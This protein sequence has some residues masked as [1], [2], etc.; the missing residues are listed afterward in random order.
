MWKSLLSI[1]H[2]P[3]PAYVF[4]VSEAGISVAYTWK[5]PAVEFHPL[6]PGA[7]RVSPIED[8]VLQPERL[9]EL[10]KAIAPPLPGKKNRDAALLL[11][12]YAVRLSILDFDSF[13]RD[14]KEQLTLVRFRLKKSVP[15]DIEAAVVSFISQPAEGKKTEVIAAVAPLEILARYE[16]PF[17]AAGLMPG[18]VT[19][20]S[21]GF[22]HLLDG[23]GL[24][25]TAKLSGRFLT[26]LVTLG[27]HLKL[28]R[29]LET[30]PE[31]P[32]LAADLYPTFVFI[33]DQLGRKAERL[34][35]CGFGPKSDEAGRRFEAELSI[36]VQA[37]ESPFGAPG[38]FNA[39]LFG[40]L[41]QL[42]GAAV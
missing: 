38:E 18:F 33:E 12:D 9:A 24:T 28:V 30:Q 37:M 25:V 4:E 2:D 41:A 35:L 36:P 6:P 20:S 1:L 14:P 8:N 13:P 10:V 19:A 23:P 15:F 22:L 11:P 42:E 17:R 31:L 7:L 16:A 40:Y 32:G 39:G 3:P 29:C 5:G 34:L 26:V 21:L 27:G